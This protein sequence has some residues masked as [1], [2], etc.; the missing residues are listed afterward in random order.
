M[1]VIATLTH[2]QGW[3][4]YHKSVEGVPPRGTR[5]VEEG[6]RCHLIVS[7]RILENGESFGAQELL[8]DPFKVFILKENIFSFDLGSLLQIE[9]IQVELQRDESMVGDAF[10]FQVSAPSNIAKLSNV[11]TNN[12]CD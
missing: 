8:V 2:I 4:R 7:V 12:L 5:C 9:K 6:A 1:V 11:D 10:V 3:I